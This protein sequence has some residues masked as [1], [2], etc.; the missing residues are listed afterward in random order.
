MVQGLLRH[1]RVASSRPSRQGIPTQIQ[2]VSINH[3]TWVLLS[4]QRQFSDKL[5]LVGHLWL[6]F[7][8]PN[9]YR[10]F[11]FAYISVG[12][13]AESA[14][15]LSTEGRESQASS[16]NSQSPER[17]LEPCLRLLTM[18][19]DKSSSFAPG[20]FIYRSRWLITWNSIALAKQSKP[21][22]N[23]FQMD[24]PNTY[25]H[26]LDLVALLEQENGSLELCQVF[27]CWHFG[28]LFVWLYWKYK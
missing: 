4:A 5:R 3:L 25:R 15:N 18:I 9:Y 23:S 2:I 17:R 19:N 28:D 14:S 1:T 6:L 20:S 10:S 22:W 16:T 7:E 21:L 24:K 27:F 8:I 11:N 26:L 12:N 13:S